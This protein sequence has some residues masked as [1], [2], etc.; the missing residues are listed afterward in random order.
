MYYQQFESER[1]MEGEIETN[2]RNQEAEVMNR[3]V[4]G[5]RAQLKDNSDEESESFTEQKAR[6]NVKNYFLF[7]Y[8]HVIYYSTIG[9]LWFVLLFWLRPIR[10]SLMNLLFIRLNPWCAFQN[11]Y[12]TTCAIVFIFAIILNNIGYTYTTL[13]AALLYSTLIN[14]FFR[15]A[16]ISGKYCTYPQSE[17]DRIFRIVIQSSTVRKEMMLDSWRGQ[18]DDVIVKE[19]ATVAKYEKIDELDVWMAKQGQ[20]SAEKVVEI[21]AHKFKETG[22]TPSYAMM[23]VLL[24]G[25]VRAVLHGLLN[26]A[27]GIRFHG[28]T[29]EEVILFYYIALWQFMYF[30]V[31]PSFYLLLYQDFKRQIYMT[32]KAI[33]VLSM[34]AIPELDHDTIVQYDDKQKKAA[35]CLAR[36]LDMYGDRFM[37]RH[38]AFIT[39]ILLH[40]LFL[41]LAMFP[42]YFDIFRYSQYKTSEIKLQCLMAIDLLLMATASILGIILAATINNRKDAMIALID[43]IADRQFQDIVMKFK[44][45]SR[46]NLMGIHVGAVYAVAVAVVALAGL[47][48]AVL[49]VFIGKYKII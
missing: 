25:A 8:L 20:R 12:W 31:G 30:S 43:K 35:L 41:I 22:S 1:P 39:F 26:L 28:D 13:D 10:T 33:Q 46:V 42:F 19:I 14:T 11:F 49:V 24:Y 18:K 23:I 48:G 21:F 16:T 45:D 38:K 15:S 34:A 44:N 47:T 17:V 5:Q 36:R 4:Q 3:L 37:Q 29:T 2:N 6:I 9:P 27:V 40:T 32:G 7:Y